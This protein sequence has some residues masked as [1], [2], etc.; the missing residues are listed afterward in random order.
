MKKITVLLLC[1]LL[2]CFS[3]SRETDNQEKR[4]IEEPTPQARMNIYLRDLTAREMEGRRTGTRGEATAAL[5]LSRYLKKLG[6]RP[7]GEEGTYF[8]AFP[9]GTIEPALVEKRMTLRHDPGKSINYSENV[10]GVLPGKSDEVVI[11]SA[12]YD[13]LGIIEDRLYPGA[14]DNGSGVAVVM[15]LAAALST[16]TPRYTILI[17]FWGGEEAGLLGSSYFCNNFT[18][19]PEK[20]NCII[21]LDSLGNLRADNKLLGW[22]NCENE[23]SRSFVN[24]LAQ[25]GWKIDW[26]ETTQH[27]SDHWSFAKAGIAGLTLLSPNWLEGNHTP[28]DTVNKINTEYLFKLMNDIK[29]GLI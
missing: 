24:K 14:N 27:N 17:A 11:L 2:L 19:S 23:F 5:Y 3:C 28:Q 22:K 26:E 4:M 8:Q 29:D 12:H 20:I 15:E 18:I 16:A 6:L 13:H 21:N 25:A 10:L 1:C 9:I 7:A